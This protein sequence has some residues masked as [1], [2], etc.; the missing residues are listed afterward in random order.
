MDA[1]LYK[2]EEQA[3]VEMVELIAGAASITVT[4]THRI[5][6]DDRRP[7]AAFELS[8]GDS[9]MVTGS[10]PATVTYVGRFSAAWEVYQLTFDPDEPVEAFLPPAVQ[11]QYQQYR[12]RER[13]SDRERER[14]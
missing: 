7:V 6:R 13:E 8:V 14:E 4:S 10:V 12:E 2:A 5:L 9:V 3:P 1:H 11:I